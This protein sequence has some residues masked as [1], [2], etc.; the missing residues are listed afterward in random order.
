MAEKQKLILD[1]FGIAA[2]LQEIAVLLELKGGQNRFK[3]K[4]YK[5]GART[6]TSVSEDL[7]SLIRSS[8]LTTLP[9][10]GNALASQIEQLYTTGESSVLTNLRAEFPTGI[11]ELSAVPGLS[12]VKIK[13]LHEELGINSVEDL[14]AAIEAGTLRTVKG[15]G[16]KTEQSLLTAIAKGKQPRPPQRLHLHHAF[17][18]GEQLVEY[19]QTAPGVLQVSYAGSLRRWKETI[20]TVRIVCS[21]KNPGKVIQHFTR[22]P[23]LLTTQVDNENSCSARFH[24]GTA[25]ALAVTPKEHFPLALWLETGSKEHLVKVEQLAQKKRVDLGVSN[26]ASKLPRSEE[27]LYERLEMQFV[28][29]EMRE[30]TGEIEAA[31]A[32]TLPEDLVALPDIKGMVHCHTTY[33]DGKHSV[34]EM[35]LA[36][37]AMGMKYITITDH[38]PTASY[39]GGLTVGSFEAT[40]GR[41]R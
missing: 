39:A 24:D 31:L 37:E 34:E 22:F 1:K 21:A 3:A 19:L 36:A 15:F 28:P 9:G 17:R 35:A 23:L 26:G 18:V 10:I 7:K 14:K 32:G 2:A 16:P 25:V 38:S 30:D 29:P 12:L 11:V 5:A 41:N 6:I 4:A 20:G 40:V 33:S 27:E 8:R 13:Q